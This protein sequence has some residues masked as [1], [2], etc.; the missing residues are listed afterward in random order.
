MPWHKEDELRDLRLLEVN[1]YF[2]SNHFVKS[3]NRNM[4]TEVS[5]KLEGPAGKLLIAI[6]ANIESWK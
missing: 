4:H 1:R 5:V 3:Y 6:L 2:I